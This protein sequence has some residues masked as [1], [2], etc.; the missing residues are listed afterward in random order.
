MILD[1][2]YTVFKSKVNNV[3]YFVQ[4]S[5]GYILYSQNE[6]NLL[7]A[8][9][10]TDD[11]IA[12]FLSSFPSA[13]STTTE[14][15]IIVSNN[16]H[17]DNDPTFTLYSSINLANGSILSIFNGSQY[18]ALKIRKIYLI[19]TATSFTTGGITPFEIQRITAHSG[20]TDITTSVE[21]YD[22]T[23]ALDSGI[24]IK[25]GATPT[26]ASSKI[27]RRV[28]FSTN[29]LQSDSV[30]LESSQNSFQSFF[31]IFEH[32]NSECKPIVLRPSDG[33]SLNCSNVMNNS[34]F[35]IEIVF[36]QI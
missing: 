22:N 8:Y 26:N 12:D 13:V 10:Y 20:G 2:G 15:D 36:T 17:V 16:L 1:V 6:K 5:Y 27:I 18:K 14:N 32:S 34:S 19:N 9:A 21:T 28:L 30:T 29:A 33:I 23:D 24:S 25:T 35:D 31:P 4:T 7:K 11:L 3:V